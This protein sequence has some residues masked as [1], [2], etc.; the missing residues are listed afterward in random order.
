MLALCLLIL[1][2]L[3]MGNSPYFLYVCLI[4][5]GW[6][7]RKISDYCKKNDECMKVYGAA[8]AE[9]EKSFFGIRDEF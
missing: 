5:F 4:D 8:S 9:L 7:G 1:L 6:I 3:L 2:A